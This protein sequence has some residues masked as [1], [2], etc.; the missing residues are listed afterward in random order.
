[1]TSARE[2][3][4]VTGLLIPSEAVERAT[5]AEGLLSRSRAVQPVQHA[6]VREARRHG[7]WPAGCAGGSPE[8]ALHVVAVDEDVVD[9]AAKRRAVRDALGQAVDG[10]VPDAGTDRPHATSACGNHS[11]TVVN[12]SSSFVPVY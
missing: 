8:S 6:T 5:H 4:H 3:G 1:M 2:V 10:Q 7:K 9:A 12:T 11:R